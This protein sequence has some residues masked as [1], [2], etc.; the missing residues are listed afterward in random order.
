MWHISFKS[1]QCPLERGLTEYSRMKFPSL[2]RGCEIAQ[3]SVRHTVDTA[4]S[5]DFKHWFQALIWVG[6]RAI[7]PWKLTL[8]SIELHENTPIFACRSDICPYLRFSCVF[9]RGLKVRLFGSPH[10]KFGKCPKVW[11]GLPKSSTHLSRV[12]LVVHWLLSFWATNHG[13][14]QSKHP[15]F[16]FC[17]DFRVNRNIRISSF[18]STFEITWCFMCRNYKIMISRWAIDDDCVRRRAAHQSC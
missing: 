1:F 16:I 5:T 17:F 10:W 15:H 12:W 14:S 8:E 18:V 3:V 9:Y 11:L 6:K 2:S 4:T 13:K 7:I